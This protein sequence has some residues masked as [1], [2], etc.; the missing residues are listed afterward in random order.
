MIRR[1]VLLGALPALGLATA[2]VLAPGWAL[3]HPNHASLAVAE[4]NPDTGR[5]EV[6]L[7]VDP[8]DLERA[9]RKATDST[10][11]PEDPAAEAH[12]EAYVRKR[13][14]VRP[15]AGKSDRPRRM[16]WVGM[17][18]KVDEAW[19]YF[20]IP[21]RGIWGLRIRN[22]IFFDLE[23]GQVNTLNLRDGD[24]RLT[25]VT[26]ADRPVATVER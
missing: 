5:L 24:T 14:V 16:K 22:A 11:R 12:V 19:L 17:E 15:P 21:I 23:D 8:D 10:I 26:N 1:R 2:V 6:A 9:I 7:K 18:I 20:E 13:F 25:F 3:A 4:L